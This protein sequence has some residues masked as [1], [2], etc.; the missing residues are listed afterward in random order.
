MTLFF[1]PSV[2]LVHDYGGL[3]IFFLRCVSLPKI[4][5]TQILCCYAAYEEEQEKTTTGVDS[6]S[7]RRDKGVCAFKNDGRKK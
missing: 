4:T 2:Y 3:Y 1:I 7:E 6:I 5:D